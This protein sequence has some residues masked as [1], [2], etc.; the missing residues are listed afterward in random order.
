MNLEPEI[1][2]VHLHPQSYEEVKAAA[3]LL[4]C[5]ES[6]PR[7]IAMAAT[8][9]SRRALRMRNQIAAGEPK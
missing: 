5:G 3:E 9:Y 7:F 1:L 8:A 2:V 4:G 6:V